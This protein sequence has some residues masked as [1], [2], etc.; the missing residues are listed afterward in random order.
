[1]YGNST[2]G[3]E[4][5]RN[6]SDFTIAVAAIT[7]LVAFAGS[8]T[9]FVVITALTPS[10]SS[11]PPFSPYHMSVDDFRGVFDYVL[12]CD[13]VKPPFSNA[14]SPRGQIRGGGRHAQG[15][16]DDGEIL[17]LGEIVLRTIS[18]IPPP[19]V[20]ALWNHFCHL[21]ETAS[22]PQILPLKLVKSII[23]FSK[24]EGQFQRVFV[25]WWLLFFPPKLTSI[26][27]S[28]C[29]LSTTKAQQVYSQ[30][31][32]SRCIVHY[33]SL[34][35]SAYSLSSY[36]LELTFPSRVPTTLSS[37]NSAKLFLKFRYLRSFY[38]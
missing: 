4:P 30:L 14:V 9:N 23:S 2:L 5:T 11:S 17:S 24:K 18:F 25:D 36:L 12:E 7:Q 10:S 29:P 20:P 3:R 32:P 8:Q 33:P 26:N 15:E 22:N 27:L 28:D 34:T 16:I 13:E 31:F 37:L 35:H 1:M 6:N 21:R 38:A 19:T